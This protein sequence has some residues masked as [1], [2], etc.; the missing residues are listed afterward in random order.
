M[1]CYN[2]NWATPP[3]TSSVSPDL[4]FEEKV[5]IEH[6][7]ITKDD[8]ITPSE[9]T[10]QIL[11]SPSVLDLP[12]DSQIFSYELPRSY[13]NE[14]NEVIGTVYSTKKV[15]GAGYRFNNP[16]L[17]KNSDHY[18]LTFTLGDHPELTI[19]DESP[20]NLYMVGS[21]RIEWLPEPT[22]LTT[23]AKIKCDFIEAK[24]SFTL[25]ESP[26]PVFFRPV[27]YG[28][29]EINGEGY[30]WMSWGYESTGDKF[31]K[32]LEGQ[33]FIFTES[34]FGHKYRLNKEGTSWV[35]TNMCTS[36]PE[37]VDLFYKDP[38]I[39]FDLYVSNSADI[40][41]QLQV[42]GVNPG[43]NVAKTVFSYIKAY[44]ESG[45]PM[46]LTPKYIQAGSDHDGF[47]RYQF[48]I[49][50]DTGNDQPYRD[51]TIN[52]DITI[53]GQITRLQTKA[54]GFPL[55]NLDFTTVTNVVKSFNWFTTKSFEPINELKLYMKKGEVFKFTENNWDGTTNPFVYLN[56]VDGYTIIPDPSSSTSLT[57]PYSIVSNGVM[58]AENIQ[59]HTYKIN[60]LGNDL[61]VLTNQVKIID[62]EI[63]NIQ[64]TI[65]QLTKGQSWYEFLGEKLLGITGSLVM[66]FLTPYL[67]VGIRSYNPDIAAEWEMSQSGIKG[68]PQL[69]FNGNVDKSVSAI[70]YSTDSIIDDNTIPT[71]SWVNTKIEAVNR[72][73]RGPDPAS[74]N[75][76]DI[77]AAVNQCPD[78]A[79]QMTR[80]NYTGTYQMYNIVTLRL[81][82]SRLLSFMNSKGGNN[83]FFQT[84]PDNPWYKVT[85]SESVSQT[86]TH[87]A[88]FTGSIDD[89]VIGSPVYFTGNVKK[90]DMTTSE[91]VSNTGPTDCISEV[92]PSGTF[93]EFA[94]VCVGFNDLTNSVIFAT[95]GDFYFKVNDSR[96]YKV[97]D[98]VLHDG[99]VLGNDEP[100]TVKVM[101]SVV[102]KVTA[103][104]DD[105][106]LAILRD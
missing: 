10:L 91:W 23:P 49:N 27:N 101:K 99:S 75:I 53:N 59:S 85:S 15:V 77:N 79:I 30:W 31:D 54:N 52:L 69:S 57:T 92:K 43:D 29:E 65:S 45:Q 58:L 3:S 102:G 21:I 98:L 82:G 37:I 60:D 93:E 11:N 50:S 62:T 51:E 81:D 95:H 68:V 73:V 8:L 6:Y 38:S 39:E 24:N 72:L 47:D 67:P 4:Q 36:F 19:S 84:A 13:I 74:G 25:Y 12:E 94:G 35:G 105:S 83:L 64:N 63:S 7:V 70:A 44:D 90:Y 96:T 20:L 17:T 78:F 87:E 46:I 33:P 28:E 61:T 5:G 26:V 16:T 76:A 2:F 104:I 86:I 41:A 100:I 14:N 9:H 89:Y 22:T 66:K 106:T 71:T 34:S 1:K 80:T 40:K 18:D 88:P 32:L 48:A 56:N 55:T 103:I 42:M 97:G